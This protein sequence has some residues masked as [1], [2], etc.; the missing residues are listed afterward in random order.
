MIHPINCLFAS[1]DGMQPPNMPGCEWNNVAPVFPVAPVA[2]V[3]PVVPVVPVAPIVPVVPVAAP[4][5]KIKEKL[6]IGHVYLMIDTTER[7][8]K[9]TLFK[10]GMT[11][12]TQTPLDRLITLRTGNPNLML[13]ISAMV[14][15]PRIVEKRLFEMA[16]QYA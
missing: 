10:L 6:D 8:D 13:G 2:P 12:P 9:C 16:Q 7:A 4:S 11:G 14:R 3:V 5:H 15:T 1:V